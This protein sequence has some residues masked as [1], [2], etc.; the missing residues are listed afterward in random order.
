MKF[1]DFN[2]NCISTCDAFEAHPLIRNWYV[3]MK[4]FKKS[5]YLCDLSNDILDNPIHRL[6][7]SG[8]CYN[9]NDYSISTRCQAIIYPETY[10]NCDKTMCIFNGKRTDE[11]HSIYDL[12][13]QGHPLYGMYYIDINV[14]ALTSY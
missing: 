1:R 2:D 12:T 5:F 3:L 7:C 4:L 13:T 8:S 10:F 11:G 9:D 14:Q 6:S